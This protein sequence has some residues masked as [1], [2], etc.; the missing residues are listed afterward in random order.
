MQPLA[1]MDQAISRQ[2][3]SVQRLATEFNSQAASAVATVRETAEHA[4]AVLRQEATQAH[5]NLGGL[6][7]E[8]LAANALNA[9]D[10]ELGKARNVVQSAVG[11]V[12]HDLGAP[13]D[14]SFTEQ[15]VLRSLP[16]SS[17][18]RIL[19]RLSRCLDAAAQEL[20]CLALAAVAENGATDALDS[21]DLRVQALKAAVG[22]LVTHGSR[23]S[24]VALA[25][26]DALTALLRNASRA[27]RP[28]ACDSLL[29][30]AVSADAAGA[31]AAALSAHTADE[32]VQGAGLGAL[33]ALLALLPRASTPAA[34]DGALAH[35]VSSQ[36]GDAA[37]SALWTHSGSAGVQAQGAILMGL[38]LQH[39]SPEHTTDLLARGAAQA[40]VAALRGGGGMDG[41]VAQAAS[42]ALLRCACLSDKA[43]ANALRYAAVP[44]TLRSLLAGAT[45]QDGV[46]QCAAQGALLALQAQ[47]ASTQQPRPAASPVQQPLPQAQQRAPP[48]SADAAVAANARAADL[49][50]K[51][52][53]D[54]V[55]VAL[56]A[57][58]DAVELLRRQM[59]EAQELLL[60]H[61]S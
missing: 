35:V 37:L 21:N 38:L 1:V 41:E 39:S 60:G 20:G 42:V 48:A 32:G 9:V 18:H 23:H 31:V 59:Q 15:P 12:I 16:G 30:A 14:R 27:P 52:R 2:M 6:A 51:A 47:S 45:P 10:E 5:K 26:C 19:G 46:A 43:V 61:E 44:D 3:D 24:A 54:A 28:D 29:L 50:A 40:L 53:Q 7:L 36:A 33:L 57:Q 25:A 56:Q 22:A 11:A 17:V 55:R 34:R 13:A 58:E 49:V 8:G 4:Q